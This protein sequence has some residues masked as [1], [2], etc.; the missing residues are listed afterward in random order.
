MLDAPADVSHHGHQRGTGTRKPQHLV[1][2]FLESHLKDSWT[3]AKTEPLTL[4]VPI[5][6]LSSRQLPQL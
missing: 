2:G 5:S 3:S 6:T 1:M 4:R